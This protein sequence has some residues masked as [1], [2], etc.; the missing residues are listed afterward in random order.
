MPLKHTLMYVRT[1]M[2]VCTIEVDRQ[3]LA[4][5]LGPQQIN[6]IDPQA[7]F[8]SLLDFR[9]KCLTFL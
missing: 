6:R 7:G 5:K 4:C 2:Y 1:Y 3:I 8:E 9:G